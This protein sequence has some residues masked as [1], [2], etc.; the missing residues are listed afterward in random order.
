MTKLS[1]RYDVLLADEDQEFIR[2]SVC[3]AY[4]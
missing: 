2:S 1:D 4:K 3:V